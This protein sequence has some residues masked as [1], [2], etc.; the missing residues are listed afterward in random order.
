MLSDRESDVVSCLAEGLSNREIAARLSISQHTVKNYMFRIFEKL[1]VSSRL[2]LLFLVMSRSGE[3][4]SSAREV[5][6]SPVQLPPRID[7]I[8]QQP[9]KVT[10]PARSANQ[11]RKE[12]AR[13]FVRN[14]VT[15]AGLP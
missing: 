7:R 12:G 4:R 11:G 13:M 9:A 3:T 6:N 8:T 5:P 14:L 10:Q 1:G 15:Q 2:E